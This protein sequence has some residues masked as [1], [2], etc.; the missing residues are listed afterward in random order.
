[1]KRLVTRTL[2]ELKEHGIGSVCVCGVRWF[3]TRSKILIYEPAKKL[4]PIQPS[5]DFEQGNH[6]R[7]AVQVHLFYTEILDEVIRYLNHI[8][9]AFDCYVSTDTKAKGLI[10]AQAM[11][12]HC[13]AKKVE[14]TCF[15]NRGRDVA[16]FLIQMKPH[17]RSYDYVCHL[18]TKYSA[19][20]DFG[21]QWRK[22]LYDSLLANTEHVS[23]LLDLFEKNPQLGLVYQKTYWHVKPSLGWKGNRAEAEALMAR[24]QLDAT[25][26]PDNPSFPAGNMFWART[27]AIASIFEAGLTSDD[28]PKEGKQLDGTL[29]HAL[30]RCW[31]HIANVHGFESVRVAVVPQKR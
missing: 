9:Y 13:Q 31:C 27:K 30:E 7:I 14:V 5:K 12:Q 16:P 17:I 20:D 26:L 1:M 25:S 19:H 11:D 18:H 6:P 21:N 10:I 4:R 22:L 29:A 15:E 3:A 8:P 2:Q 28:F 23:A 24:R